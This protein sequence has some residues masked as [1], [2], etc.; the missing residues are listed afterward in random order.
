MTKKECINKIRTH[1]PEA[2]GIRRH[3]QKIKVDRIRRCILPEDVVEKCEKDSAYKTEMVKRYSE[4]WNEKLTGVFNEMDYVI[5]KAPVYQ[6]RSDIESIKTDIL[7]CRLA[8]GFIPSEYTAFKFIDKSPKERKEFYSDTDTY[9]FGYSVNNI[10]TVQKILDKSE[11]AKF[12]GKYFKRDFVIVKNKNDWSHF[13]KFVSEHHTFMKKKIF[14][15]MGKGI[16]LVD[17]DSLKIK[18]KQYFESL[19]SEGKWLLEELVKQDSQMAVFNKTSVNTIRC[20]T[21]R[22]DD[23]IVIPYCILRTGREGSIVD[24]GGSGGVLMGV[25]VKTGITDTNGYDEFGEIYEKHP[26][27]GIDLKG[28][29]VPRW[30]EMTSFC[31]EAAKKCKTLG[32]LAWDMALTEKGWLVI[33]VNEVGQILLPQMVYEKGLK[34]QFTGYLN[35]MES[36]I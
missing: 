21:L 4:K 24:N 22:T 1:Y 15:S 3:L 2:F 9:Q 18:P 26:D 6:N 33:E 17:F 23:G 13:K 30:E 25:N 36:M 34:K 28:F 29:Q 16:E 8:Y 35:K 5:E 14:S 11:S 31:K 10:C 7:F 20:M 27:S 32:Y 12:F 19:I